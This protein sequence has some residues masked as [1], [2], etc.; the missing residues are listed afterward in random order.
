MG[1]S[2]LIAGYWLPDA[3]LRHAQAARGTDIDGED[4]Q[5]EA[6]TLTLTAC[7]G[8]DV[9]GSRLASQMPAAGGRRRHARS[10]APSFELG[11]LVRQRAWGSGSPSAPTSRRSTS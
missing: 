11:P 5:R 6:P 10:V 4:Q 9:V 3:W 1:V 2:H 8:A 7:L